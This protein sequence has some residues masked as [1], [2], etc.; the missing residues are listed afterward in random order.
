VTPDLRERLK[1]ALRLRRPLK[2]VWESARTWSVAALLLMLLQALLPLASL[3][4]VKLTVDAV[5][6]GIGTPDKAAAL[7]SV[8]L[9]VTLTGASAMLASACRAASGVVQEHQGQ[10][11]TDH[12]A[13]IIHRQSA[14]I[15]L[16][17]YED[18]RYHDS[19]YRAQREAPYR[20]TRVVRGLTQ[21]AQNAVSL[22]ALAG[23]LSWLHPAVAAVLFGTVLPVVLVRIA[24]AD[25]LYFWRRRR[26]ETERRVY[27]YHQMLTGLQ[28]AKELRLFNLGGV[29]MQRY[30]DL[31]AVMRGERLDLAKRRSA[32]ELLA[33]GAAMLALFG[34]L[35]FVAWRTLQ[36]V[37][38]LGDM[39][40]YHQAFQRA[41]S[42]LQGIMEGLAGLYEDSLFLNDFSAF[43]DLKPEIAA[44][45]DPMTPPRPMRSGICFEDVRFRYPGAGREVL[46]GADLRIGP[47]EVVALVGENGA[48]KSTLAKLLCRLYDPTEGRITFDGADFRL[49][50]PEAL[51]RE[52]TAIFQDYV[53][54]PLSVREN[55]WIG[56]V[57]LDPLDGRVEEAARR[58]GAEEMIGR[59]SEG[60]E[61]LLG[62]RF[63]KGEELSIGEWQK[64]A[65]ARAFLRDAQLI[66]LDEPTSSM[67]ARTEHE[68][69]QSFHTLLKERSA[70][71]IS[72]RFSTTRM[73]DTI[74]VMEEGR[75]VER[76]SHDELLRTGGRYA[77][78]YGLQAG[79]YQ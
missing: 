15:G 35:A 58:A 4:L 48:G 74:C 30:R 67:S 52:I 45:A 65:L 2:L 29:F 46:H 55:I 8:L 78:M 16:S 41:Q 54:Y 64:I 66:V 34:M 36:G 53:Q 44:P 75:I 23:M 9:L 69:F 70:L 56:D 71:L 13:D 33:Q 42:A 10:L 77:R 50:D 49:F 14:V 11:V 7:R 12:V 28:H 17:C 26:T 1:G 59:L 57:R 72:H 31:R 3:Y 62:R 43:L 68:F 39:V 47:G 5:A 6:E 79:Y 32:A 76:G 73:A 22:G 27:E 20:P 21:L 18:P 19:L 38:T 61:T 24:S 60:Y 51:R 25:R 37:M 40:M 63:E